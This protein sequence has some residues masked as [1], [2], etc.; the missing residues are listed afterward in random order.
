M[1]K[2]R[3]PTWSVPFALLAACIISFGLLIPWLGFYWDDWP[4]VWFL[5]FLG[6]EG[7]QEVFASDR[8]LLGWLFLFTTSIFG[9]DPINWQIFGLI[10]RWLSGVTLWWVL[11]LLWPN[12]SQVA[13][14]IAL[15]FVLY[16]GFSQ[17][18][19]ALTYSHV[20]I[21]LTLFNLSLVTM[22]LG[23]KHRRRF[24][25]FYPLS[26]LLSGLS[27][28][29]VE[30]FFGL[31]LLR[32]VVLWIELKGQIEPKRKRLGRVLLYWIPYLVL[33][34]LFL[35]WRVS[36]SET[37]RG[38][39]QIFDKLAQNPFQEVVSL[40]AMITR[41]MVE[42][43]LVAWARTLR[44]LNPSTFGAAATSLY[45]LI[46]LAAGFLTFFYLALN[47]RAVVN[48]GTA[49]AK[50]ASWHTAGLFLLAGLYALFVAGWP[51]WATGLPV[52]LY[53]PWDRFTL[54][55]MPG[56]TLLIISIVVLVGR[57]KWIP[58]ILVSLLAGFA[59]GLHFQNANLYRR[60]WNMQKA[61]FWQLTWR[62][63]G[64]EPG[65]MLL[66]SEL[67]YTHFSDNSLTAPLNWTYSPDS[68]PEQ[69]PYL[70]YQVESRL[71]T[72]LP[73]L[74]PGLSIEEPYRA[75]SFSGSTDQ[76]IVFYYQPPGC[77]QV[78]D[79]EIHTSL[80]QKPKYLSDAMPLS[81][82]S[83]IIP[84]GESPAVPPLHILGPEPEPDWCYYFERADLARQAADWDAVLQLGELAFD[85]NQRLYPV[86]A[87]EY[88]PYIEGYAQT[89]DWDNAASL[90]LAAYDLNP[91]MDRVLCDTWERFASSSDTGQGE[92][93]IEELLESLNCTKQ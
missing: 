61:M 88:L 65:T 87:P 35:V 93:I 44:P 34:I 78:L 67:P 83:L 27:M 75:T 68:L 70:M 91:R 11:R 92:N 76:A 3:F 9:E 29:S 38:E 63:P 15:L 50:P 14:W 79:P 18:F 81:D 40:A 85:L 7:F 82:V 1:P 84:Q 12:R 5:H 66:T 86:N 56:A 89:G 32:P 45:L 71:G 77:V 2:L 55:M 64:L 46:V 59:V 57:H 21:I 26:I 13:A 6:P 31:E 28:F 54:A 17:Q 24:W 4:A 62:A 36:L 16:P 37:P 90:T 19:I 10:T 73:D 51:F 42:A 52:D 60:E 23:L 72:S 22:I 30:Y 33:M 20:F 47:R 58:L 49:A 41:D 39:V 69:M 48:H 74:L 53:F 8:P 80:P 43:S 25:L